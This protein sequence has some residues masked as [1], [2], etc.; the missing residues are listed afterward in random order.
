MTSWHGWFKPGFISWFVPPLLTPLGL[1]SSRLLVFTTTYNPC[2]N[3]SDLNRAINDLPL[4]QRNET[5]R[6]IFPNPPFIAFKKDQNIREKL[7]RAKF[8]QSLIDF[9]STQQLSPIPDYS[10]DDS[11]FGK[12][13][14]ETLE[15]LISLLEEQVTNKQ[16]FYSK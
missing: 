10:S 2:I 12:G 15:I 5:L 9:I 11:G 8:N 6:R 3:H 13:H 14:D 16:E 1:P 4:I 7:I